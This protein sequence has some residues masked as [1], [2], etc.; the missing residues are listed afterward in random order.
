MPIRPA[1]PL[2][3]QKLLYQE[4]G[5]RCALCGESDVPK[6]I[7]H[8]IIPWA[9]NPTHDPKHM[10]V[11]CAN[12][13]S[14]A[15][16]GKVSPEELCRAKQN[17]PRIIPLHP[18]KGALGSVSISGDGN[19]VVGG[20]FQINPRTIQRT[21]VVPGPGSILDSEALK[22]RTLINELAEIDQVAG[23]ADSHAKWYKKLY[24]HFQVTSYKLIPASRAKEAIAWLQRQK[25]ISRPKLRRRNNDMWRKSLYKGIFARMRQLGIPK[26]DVYHIAFEHLGLNK[27][28][29]S[30]T[31]LGER[32]LSR[33]HQKIISMH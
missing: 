21:Q 1:V 5:S 22:V 27:P 2:G 12:C 31:E 33:L 16:A 7:I 18:A 32:D 8:H 6:L 10:V 13:H 26:D 25:A 20:N 29:S 24:R 19:F 11:L 4:A 9:D 23:R 15:T 3:I 28:I 30:L 17:E 14:L